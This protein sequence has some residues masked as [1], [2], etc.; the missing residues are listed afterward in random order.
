MRFSLFALLPL[1]SALQLP[2][3]P[4]PQSAL[5]A[6]DAILHSASDLSPASDLNLASIPVDDHVL[7]T[8]ARHPVRLTLSV[9]FGRSR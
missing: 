3:L 4:T 5:R 9:P 7:I 1:I 2:H 6:A 8:S